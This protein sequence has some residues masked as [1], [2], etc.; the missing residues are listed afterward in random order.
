MLKNLPNSEKNQEDTLDR[1]LTNREEIIK[2]P[3]QRTN[4]ICI[5]R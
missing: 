3:D 2:M 4:R 5:P 1:K